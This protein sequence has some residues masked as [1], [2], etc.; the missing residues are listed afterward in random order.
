MWIDTSRVG[1][2]HRGPR[3]KAV[4]MCRT[5]VL[6]KEARVMANGRL[7]GSHVPRLELVPRMC[8]KQVLTLVADAVLILNLS[9]VAW[10]RGSERWWINIGPGGVHFQGCLRLPHHPRMSRQRHGNH[11]LGQTAYKG[12]PASTAP[13][14]PCICLKPR[15][16]TVPFAECTAK[17]YPSKSV[18]RLHQCSW[19]TWR[20]T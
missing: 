7:Q 11:L 17:V 15:G 5:P 9:K 13:N 19:T 2:R 18:V 14:A 6:P 8:I 4:C 10:F 20:S 1:L 16:K 3:W 12:P